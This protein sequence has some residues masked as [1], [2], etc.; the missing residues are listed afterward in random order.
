MWSQIIRTRSIEGITFSYLP[1]GF[2][3]T[4]SADR[5]LDAF[6][7]RNSQPRFNLR[8]PGRITRYF[9]NFLIFICLVSFL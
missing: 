7:S 4:G 8:C 2:L 6:D 9:L 3:V 1:N 5:Y